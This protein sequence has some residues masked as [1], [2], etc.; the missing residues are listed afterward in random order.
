MGEK[1]L[2]VFNVTVELDPSAFADEYGTDQSAS[3]DARE[4]AATAYGMLSDRMLHAVT[5][6]G[7]TLPSF[8]ECNGHWAKVHVSESE[9][10]PVHR[11]ALAPGEPN[12]YDADRGQF[13]AVCTCGE[14]F[15]SDGTGWD[16]DC[17]LLDHCETANAEPDA[18]PVVT[19]KYPGKILMDADTG[20]ITGTAPEGW[21]AVEGED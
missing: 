14:V 21:R 6:R 5:V 9:L 3:A 2:M 19:T 16:A 11:D 4:A 20:E 17:L 15:W 7:V 10:L 8:G 13:K 18:E 1:R 12:P